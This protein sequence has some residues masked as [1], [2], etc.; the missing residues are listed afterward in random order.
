[1]NKSNH[2]Y[3][4]LHIIRSGDD[5]VAKTA[6]KPMPG[7]RPRVRPKKQWLDR[8]AEDMHLVNRAKWQKACKQADP[9]QMQDTR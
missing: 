4:F 1:M 9:A 3:S 8:L 7:Q 5:T 6:Y 2:P